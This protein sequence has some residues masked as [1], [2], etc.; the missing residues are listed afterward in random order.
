[1]KIV[2]MFPAFCRTPRFIT[3]CTRVC[4]QVLSWTKWITLTPSHYTSKVHFT[5]TSHPCL[6]L[7]SGL[8]P[9]ASPIKI[10]HTFIISLMQAKC[11]KHLIIL[12]L[13]NRIIFD[14]KDKSWSSWLCNF[15]QSP[16]TSSLSGSSATHSQAHWGYFL[17]LM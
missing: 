6:G 2:K 4:H 17:P 10:P 11:P 3:L 14:K 15:L 5:L 8:F 9:L 13:I 16:V 12:D 1:V 7:P